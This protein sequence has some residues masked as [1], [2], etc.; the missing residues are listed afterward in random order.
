MT[1]KSAFDKAKQLNLIDGGSG[2][3]WSEEDVKKLR[4]AFENSGVQ[5]FEPRFKSISEM[6]GRSQRQ[7]MIKATLMGF[8]K[9]K[10]KKHEIK[11]TLIEFD[12]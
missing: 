8:D 6:L 2:D 4:A 9:K 5:A 7:C 10:P 1:E 12:N 3:D 11:A